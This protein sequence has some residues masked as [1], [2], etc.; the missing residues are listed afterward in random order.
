MRAR[1]R[2]VR[3]TVS[4]DRVKACMHMLRHIDD[5]RELRKNPL[6]AP[7]LSRAAS[8]TPG[9]TA[10]RQALATLRRI[11]SRAVE[12]LKTQ[13]GRRAKPTQIERQY[14]ILMRCDLGGE[15]ASAVAADLGICMRQFYR[16]HRSACTIIAPEIDRLIY[17]ETREPARA[18]DRFSMAF[19][20][21]TT[22]R[23]AGS[24]DPAIDEL[25][26]LLAQEQ[27]D[28]KKASVLARLVHIFLDDSRVDDAERELNAACANAFRGVERTSRL[29]DITELLRSRVEWACGR[30]HDDRDRERRLTTAINALGSSPNALWREVACIALISWSEYDAFLGRFA[31]SKTLLERA[32]A[33]AVGLTDPSPHLQANLLLQTAFH[34]YHV[35]HREDRAREQLDR[36]TRIA[37]KYGFIEAAA[38][39]LCAESSIVQ[40]SGALD[41]AL[42]LAR[43][44]EQLS[45]TGA[46]SVARARVLLRVSELEAAIGGVGRSLELSVAARKLLHERSYHAMGARYETARAHQLLGNDALAACEAMQLYSDASA[47]GSGRLAG[48]ALRLVAETQSSAGKTREAAE[49]IAEAIVLLERHGH[50]FSL[51]R[52]YEVSARVTGNREHARRAR[53]IHALYRAS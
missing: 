12:H 49:V 50:A 9:S 16:E 32:D 51:C 33:I 5:V 3:A 30:S 4:D 46:A 27:S 39:V 41:R 29:H 7:L 38:N 11:L 6:V 43:E 23:L 13:S 26:S 19:T 42:Q 10:S 8:E 15:R 22:L 25:R 20:R 2:K 18:F 45:Q 44:A 24:I 31:S 1:E 53:E 17:E 36:L 37:R 14:A 40:G 34:H 28:E 48:S 47:S 21:A 52:A 35:G